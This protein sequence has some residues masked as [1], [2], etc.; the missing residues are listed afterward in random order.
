MDF[1][2]RRDKYLEIKFYDRNQIDRKIE[3]WLG[4]YFLCFHSRFD[5]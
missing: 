2:E 1:T 5:C 4:G 3:W